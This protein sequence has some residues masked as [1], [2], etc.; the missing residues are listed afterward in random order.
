MDEVCVTSLYQVVQNRSFILLAANLN[1]DLISSRSDIQ[2]NTGIMTTAIILG[3][4]TSV[5]CPSAWKS[6]HELILEF[7]AIDIPF[8]SD[9]MVKT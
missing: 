3:N 5:I 2:M 6:E 4:P 8:P 1:Q 9:W 7:Q